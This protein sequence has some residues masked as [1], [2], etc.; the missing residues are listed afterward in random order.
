MITRIVKMTFAPDQV[1]QFLENF[2]SVQP[3]IQD[4]TGCNSVRLM[5][6]EDQPNVVFTISIW[7]SADDLEAYRHSDLFKNTWAKTK[8]KFEAKPQAWSLVEANL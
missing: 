7:N 3:K 5:Q 4:F 2:K 8:P 1:P 6:Q